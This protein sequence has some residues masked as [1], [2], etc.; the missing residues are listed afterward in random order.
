MLRLGAA[1]SFVAFGI[2]LSGCAPPEQEPVPGRSDAAKSVPVVRAERRAYDGAP[3]TIPHQAQGAD[4]PTCHT[5]VGVAVEGL[6][7]APASPH[8]QTVGLGMSSRCRQCH[9]PATTNDV[10]VESEF[11]GEPQNL[12]PGPRMYALAP[13]TIPHPTF[14][15][16]NCLACHDGAAA[17][18][19]IRT[20][21][22]E[23]TACRQCHAERVTETTW[24]AHR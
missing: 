19:A 22:P 10:W 20:S 7:F 13:P 12:E 1:L 15:R 21:H 6:G 9:V 18:E 2:V 23:R 11:L 3:P 24:P 5:R 16:E 17:R 4:C 8:E 14:M